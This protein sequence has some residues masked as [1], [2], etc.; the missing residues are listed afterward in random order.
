MHNKQPT[1][2]ISLCSLPPR[3]PFLSRF[4]LC[5]N[6]KPANDYVML[7]EDR[8]LTA[9]G[10]Q[11]S[12]R[13]GSYLAEHKIT[14]PDW[15]FCSPSVRTSYTLELVRRHWASNV[16]VAFENILYVLAFND[17]FAFVAGLNRNFRRVLIVG[18]N[19]AILNTAKKLMNEHGLEDFPTAGFLEISWDD[20]QFWFNMYPSTGEVRVAISGGGSDDGFF[21]AM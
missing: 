12:E 7:D 11:Q 8:P 10:M 13:L 1:T 4:C 5:T 17:Y 9:I 3:P 21:N 2:N 20:Q 18:H 19:P 16:P 14:P 15:I 6:G